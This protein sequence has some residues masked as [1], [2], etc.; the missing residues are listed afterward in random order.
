VGAFREEEA[1]KALGL[2][3]ELRPVA[4]VPV[5]YPEHVPRSA[6]PRLPKEELIFYL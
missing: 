3:P 5:G 6:P 1:A 4:L 2:P